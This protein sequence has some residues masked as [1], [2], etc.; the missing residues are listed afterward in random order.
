MNLSPLPIQKF[1]DNNGEP[2][3]GGLLFTYEAGTSVKVATYIDS[4]GGTPNSNPVVLD[5]RGECRL[6]IDPRLAYKYVLAPKGDTDP[7]TKPIWSVDNITAA[8]LNSDNAAVDTGSVNNIALSIPQ[9]TSPV[10]F[11]RIV[12]QASHT[13]TGP[14][15]ISIN[16]GTSK[17]LLWQNFGELGGAEIQTFGIYEAIYDGG[18]WQLQGPTLSPP[19]LRSAA[20][21]TALVT[22]TSYSYATSAFSTDLR[23]YGGTADNATDNAAAIARAITVISA[24]GGGQLILG[25]TGT[26]LTS[27]FPVLPSN[28]VLQGSGY[29]TILKYTGSGSFITANS[30]SSRV[31]IREMQVIG[32]A[33]T[34]T[35]LVLGDASGN[36]GWVDLYR[37]LFSGFNL[38]MR[39]GG[40]T[41]LNCEKCEFGNANGNTLGSITNNVGIDF[42]YFGGSN[43]S[44]E[45]TFRD[46]VVSNN[47]NAGVQAT[48]VPVTMNSVNWLECTVQNNC[49]S[50]LAN[51]QFY[52][53]VVA[54]FTIQEMYMEYILGGTPPDAIRSDNMNSGSITDTYIN[55]AVNGIKDRGGGSMNQVDIERVQ[56]IGITTRAIDCVSEHDVLV[57]STVLG[58]GTVQLTGVGCNFL[59]VT[60]GVASWP[61]A[62]TNFT[63]TLISSGGGA[64]TYS[65]Q[66][67]V[68]SKV[69][70][71]I[72][73]KI[74]IDTSAL[75]TLAAG[76]VSIAGL[77]IASVNQGN[78]DIFPSFTAGITPVG[79][80]NTFVG[81]LPANATAVAIY[82]CGTAAPAQVLV[83]GLAAATSIAISGSYQ[84]T[85]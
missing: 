46:C 40:A 48:N 11:T 71:V 9:I 77:P 56:M 29:G 49:Q 80:N 15:T 35:A 33:R 69:G 54:G 55:T 42:N 8:P 12:F 32:T 67:G 68:Y 20:E 16:G 59:P 10:A 83:A 28:V 4:S 45:L 58:G 63:P 78:G 26:Y 60:S 47:A 5:F 21:I 14:T 25:E 74:R 53:G 41:W 34:G 2:L 57:R 50:T 43:Y 3:V 38:A 1:F 39:V 66:Q 62:L 81:F 82:G 22:P 76:S 36:A 64:P 73:Y 70:N 31:Q 24:A 44:S 79:T 23:R 37:V 18:Q 19:E 13:N 17:R 6:W 85:S 84:T 27:A 61:V 75:G 7:P 72:S 30:T 51:P 65:T 52:M